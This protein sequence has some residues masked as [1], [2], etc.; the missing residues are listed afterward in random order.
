MDQPVIDET[1]KFLDALEIIQSAPK[2]KVEEIRNQFRKNQGNENSQK[3]GN[4]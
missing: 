4:D 3:T 1:Q 2:E